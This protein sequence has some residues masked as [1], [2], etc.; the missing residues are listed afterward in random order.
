MTSSNAFILA[1]F[2]IVSVCLGPF[3]A[4][5]QT[6]AETLRQV[7]G[8]N[9]NT[10]DPTMPGATREAFGLS[11]SL[12][13]RLLTFDRKIEN[14][15]RVFDPSRLRGELAESYE[16]SPD[17]LKITFKLRAAKWSDGSPVTAEDV[18]WSL[19]R[20]VSAKSLSAG[21]IASGSLTRPEQFVVVDD[22]T[23]EV[24]LDKAD[25]LALANLAIPLTP[26][27]N[28][29]LVK[30][31]A[32]ADDPWGQEWLK[33]NAAGGGAYVVEAFRPGE[34]VI[35]RRNEEWKNGPDG[36]P[37]FFKRVIEQ[38]IPEAS[39]RASL[40]EKGDADIAIDLLAT[41]IPTLQ[42][43]GKVRVESTPQS[44]GFTMIAFN[45]QMPP[46]DNAAVRQ[47]IA[48]ALPYDDMFNAAIIRQG[49]PLFNASWSSPPNGAFPQPMPVRT[50]LD[51]ARRLL[52]EAGLEKGFK[53]TFTINV[54]SAPITEPM[55]A[56]IK[57]ALAKLNIEV[58]IQKLPDAQMGTFISEK[59]LALFTEGS[60]A[61]LP[62][63]DYFFRTFF[64][65][66]QRWNYSS[67][68]NDTVLDLATRARFELD[69]VDED[70]SKR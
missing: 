20:A 56:L 45:T 40:I 55:A 23:I 39:T 58:E 24:H 51:K 29:K 69:P 50:D 9:I 49:R 5:A 62:T 42:G 17:G 2:G 53:T 16:I 60:S 4:K 57:E 26:M 15:V 25:R 1:I 13:D 10:L 32:N 8:N 41:E 21:Q 67:W 18:K 38:T 11:L 27:F 63:T 61:W 64:T 31:H 30:Q 35:L 14:N 66:T 3:E 6:R 28:S 34:Q 22:R 44:N 65:G 54:G 52:A 36:K 59:K 48:A 7:T 47:A 68:K 70:M 46:F 37:A 12:Y 43:R 19:D 33:T